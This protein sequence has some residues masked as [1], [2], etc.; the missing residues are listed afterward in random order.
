MTLEH[1]YE[2]LENAVKQETNA[3]EQAEIF[4]I[5]SIIWGLMFTSVALIAKAESLW[6]GFGFVIFLVVAGTSIF[7]RKRSID[8][9][10]RIFSARRAKDVAIKQFLG[11]NEVTATN[12]EL[13][14]LSFPR[15][16]VPKADCIVGEALLTKHEQTVNAVLSFRAGKFS[17]AVRKPRAKRTA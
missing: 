4:T 10:N 11:A 12:F 6:F 15:S 2:E 7:Y 16:G 8:E 3:K 5:F 9:R 17:L 14:K 13:E 1:A